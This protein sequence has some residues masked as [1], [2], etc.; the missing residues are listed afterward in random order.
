M[1]WCSCTGHIYRTHG[2]DWLLARTYD[3]QIDFQILDRDEGGKEE[4]AF[5]EA[6]AHISRQKVEQYYKPVEDSAAYYAAL[7][8]LPRMKWA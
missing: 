4:Y 7:V 5:L 6:A 8:L 3:A 2:T 1:F